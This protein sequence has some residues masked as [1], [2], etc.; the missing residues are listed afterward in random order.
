MILTEDDAIREILKLWD[1]TGIEMPARQRELIS[2]AGHSGYAL[3]NSVIERINVAIASTRP[4]DQGSQ[5]LAD[6]DQ[7]YIAAIGNKKTKVSRL[8]RRSENPRSKIVQVIQLVSPL[9][10]FDEII[11]M[12]P[13]DDDYLSRMELAFLSRL[14]VPRSVEEAE[15]VYAKILELPN[16]FE[17]RSAA[18]KLSSE[19][20][21]RAQMFFAYLLMREHEPDS[22][23]W[24]Y[25]KHSLET[26]PDYLLDVPNIPT[27][28]GYSS[29]PAFWMS[30]INDADF[31]EILL[32]RG[33]EEVR[34]TVN[35]HRE[36]MRKV[37]ARATVVRSELTDPP[38]PVG[39]RVSIEQEDLIASLTEFEG[40][41]I[42]EL[43]VPADKFES[44]IQDDQ[45]EKLNQALGPL[46]LTEDVEALYK[47]R[48]GFRSR[49]DML[50]FPE[51]NP[52][53]LAF[54]EYSELA[55][56][57]DDTWSRVWYPLCGRGRSLRLTL[58]TE[59]YAP[60]TPVFAYDIEN[61]E[62]QLEFESLEMMVRTYKEAYETGLSSYNESI[63]GF[64]FDDAALE[65][66]RLEI[67]PRAYSYPANRRNA[68]DVHNPDSWPPLWRKYQG[69]R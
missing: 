6:I 33:S 5:L 36:Y 29:R 45:I 41:V 68:Y 61:G 37:E 9:V 19:Q 34:D 10:F 13:F 4:V 22:E 11:G 35:R 46:R 56:V 66:L 21:F 30:S 31:Q 2:A 52:I 42:G 16:R 38:P 17:R 58:L 47:W 40:R 3:A 51:F 55:D 24:H 18:G 14:D 49:I 53:E 65:K 60:S 28:R 43:P 59:E 15:R 64:D 63:E 20:P 27:S 1:A 26:C 69:K 23:L 44:S 7:F 32:E 67:N 25:L 57:L 50:G 39:D 8:R 54:H 48:N 62:L 12:Q